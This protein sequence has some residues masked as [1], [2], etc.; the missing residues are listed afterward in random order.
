MAP[1]RRRRRI[2]EPGGA[3]ERS[4]FLIVHPQEDILL[5]IDYGVE[6]GD[7]GILIR[8]IRRVEP[9]A[10]SV[11]AVSGRGVIRRITPRRIGEYGKDSRIG[12]GIY[13][14]G[15]QVSRADLRACQA[16]YAGRGARRAGRV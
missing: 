10:A 1:G 11:Q 6:P 13:A 4:V 7:V 3:V 5:L 15:R 8:R 16:G 12:P 9:E 2:R 14:I